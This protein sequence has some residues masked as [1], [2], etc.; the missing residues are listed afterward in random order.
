MSTHD[1]PDC[2]W[3]EQRL[4][5]TETLKEIKESLKRS[6]NRQDARDQEIYKRLTSLQV[7]EGKL[8]V[9]SGVWGLAG[10]AVAGL[11]ILVWDKIK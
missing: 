9:K 10:S 5:L 4:H 11:A 6:E 7:E 3:K 1:C 8:K 2:D